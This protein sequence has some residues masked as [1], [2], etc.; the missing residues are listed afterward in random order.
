MLELKEKISSAHGVLDSIVVE[1]KDGFLVDGIH[2]PLVLNSGDRVV[3]MR[4]EYLPRM[5]EMIRKKFGTGGETIVFDQGFAYG[6]ATWADVTVKF[7]P[8]FARSNLRLVLKLYQAL[9]WL[10]LEGIEWDEGSRSV[11][12]RTSGSSEC[13]GRKSSAPYSQFVR[14]HL[15]GALTAIL[16]KETTCKETRCIAA[17]DQLCEFVSTPKARV[18]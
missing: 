13:E 6:K 3:L 12:I 2:F 7:G 10:R 18:G 1:S 4:A 14:G 5:F 8:G 15:S 16:G 9:G 11:T 17:G